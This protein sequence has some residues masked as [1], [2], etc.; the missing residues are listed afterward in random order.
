MSLIVIGYILITS[1]YFSYEVSKD[2]IL[3]LN[4]L[5][6]ILLSKDIAGNSNKLILLCIV[7]NF[8]NVKF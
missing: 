6:S 5:E 2:F 4:L 1:L 3:K 7:L 8:E